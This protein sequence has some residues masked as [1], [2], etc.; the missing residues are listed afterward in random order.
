LR[1][2]AILSA[3]KMVAQPLHHPQQHQHRRQQQQGQSEHQQ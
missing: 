2:R 1:R 3:G